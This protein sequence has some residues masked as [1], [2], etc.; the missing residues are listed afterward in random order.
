MANESFPYALAAERVGG[1]LGYLGHEV[2]PDDPPV[3]GSECS[4]AMCTV[5]A[6]YTACH[7][8]SRLGRRREPVPDS[9]VLRLDRH[10]GTSGCQFQQGSEGAG[11]HDPLP[12][13]QHAVPFHPLT[14]LL[15]AGTT[16]VPCNLWTHPCLHTII[17][18]VGIIWNGPRQPTHGDSYA[19]NTPED[20]SISSYADTRRSGRGLW[21]RP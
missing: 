1:L 15:S 8:D 6:A 13:T 4:T 10:P 9:R 14:F 19:I 16:V 11:C 17:V 18:V 7:V 2:T 21:I 20:G 5:M 3:S 12:P